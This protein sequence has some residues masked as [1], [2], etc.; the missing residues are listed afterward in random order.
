M[1]NFAEISSEDELLQLRNDGKVS[2]TEYQE[3]LETMKKASLGGDE[4][5]ASGTSKTESKRK[6]GK[7]AL[8][9]MLSGFILPFS[10]FFIIEALARPN[11]GA[12]IGPWFFLGF[13]LELAALV[14]GVNAW[15]DD[16]GKGAVAGSVAIIVIALLF[17]L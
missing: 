9:L 15:T 8:V 3:L 14:M 11:A 7:I 12:A 4:K 13:A 6:L 17:I 16:F 10:C 2:E 5:L 1:D